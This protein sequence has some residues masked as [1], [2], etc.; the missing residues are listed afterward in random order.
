ME[1]LDLGDDFLH[2]LGDHAPVELPLSPFSSPVRGLYSIEYD[3]RSYLLRLNSFK[4][5]IKYYHGSKIQKSLFLSLC[6][7]SDSGSDLLTLFLLVRVGADL[8]LMANS[9]QFSSMFVIILFCWM[10]AGFPWPWGLH[11]FSR[12]RQS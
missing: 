4:I 12:L 9:S 6:C 7:L 3:V 2:H 11:S 5:V 10:C 1:I 8:P